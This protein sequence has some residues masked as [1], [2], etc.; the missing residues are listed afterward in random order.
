MLA[1]GLA[2]V[3]PMNEIGDVLEE[4]WDTQPRFCASVSADPSAGRPDPMEFADATDDPRVVAY[5]RRYEE[6]ARQGQLR[7]GPLAL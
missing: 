2:M 1:M 6:V 5:A 3:V 4:D 7:E